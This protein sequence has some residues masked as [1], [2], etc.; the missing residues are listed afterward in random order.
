MPFP[1]VPCRAPAPQRFIMVLILASSVLLTLDTPTLD[2]QS[3]LAVVLVNVDI[4][5]TAFFAL[6]MAI[7]IVAKVRGVRG[8]PID[9]GSGGGGV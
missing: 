2:P 5:F 8:A 7:K 6:E 4:V 3:T 9:A 1:A